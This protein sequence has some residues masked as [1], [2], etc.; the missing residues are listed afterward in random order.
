MST[1]HRRPTAWPARALRPQWRNRLWSRRALQASECVVSRSPSVAWPFERLTGRTVEWGRF[2]PG[3]DYVREGEFTRDLT[4]PRRLR[5]SA[6]FAR[7]PTVEREG[8]PR[9]ARW[10]RLGLVPEI[11]VEPTR[12]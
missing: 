10:P 12:F 2:F 7:R 11:G 1:H 3:Q 5:T 6:V 9:R 4:R 8:F